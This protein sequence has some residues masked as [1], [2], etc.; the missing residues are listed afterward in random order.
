MLIEACGEL[1]PFSKIVRDNDS[2]DCDHDVFDGAG[3]FHE[4]PLTFSGDRVYF[5]IETLARQRGQPEEPEDTWGLRFAVE[6]VGEQRLAPVQSAR[7]S[8]SLLS[9]ESVLAH[10]GPSPY[11]SQIALYA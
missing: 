6:G 11:F 9:L 8:V 5:V 4:R 1:Y 2:A 3:R 10:E 7:L